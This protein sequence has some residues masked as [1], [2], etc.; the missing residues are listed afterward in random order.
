MTNN[1]AN[2]NFIVN[3]KY[4][5]SIS[6]VARFSTA[7]STQSLDSEDSKTSGKP[8]TYTNLDQAKQTNSHAYS[9]KHKAEPVNKKIRPSFFKTTSHSP[10]SLPFTDSSSSV[11]STTNSPDL[12]TSSFAQRGNTS[13]TRSVSPTVSISNVGVIKTE[14]HTIKG[15]TRSV[16]PSVSTANVGVMKTEEHTTKGNT[17]SVSPSVSTANVGVNKTEERTSKSNTR[18]TAFKTSTE[19]AD[20]SKPS[21]KD[22]IQIQSSIS[23]KSS[24]SSVMNHSTLAGHTSGMYDR[25]TTM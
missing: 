13:T 21:T 18:T 4:L 3:E 24:A 2:N 25:V 16:S 10:L 20:L 22:S 9:S 6:G 12:F 5:V 7:T 14:E 11:T 15:N 23:I 19:T 1:L 8:I 17:R